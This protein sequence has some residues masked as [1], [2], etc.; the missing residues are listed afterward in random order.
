[1]MGVSILSV[2]LPGAFKGWASFLHFFFIT[3]SVGLWH[4]A[5]LTMTAMGWLIPGHLRDE[6]WGWWGLGKGETSK[7]YNAI[8]SSYFL[9]LNWSLSLRNSNC[10]P[11][12]SPPSRNGPVYCTWLVEFSPWVM[13]VIHQAEIWLVNKSVEFL[14]LCNPC[15]CVCVLW[16]GRRADC[17]RWSSKTLHNK[18]YCGITP[19]IL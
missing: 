7:G 17:W 4:T 9:Q 16:K 10:N 13:F 8:S 11:R 18:L 19:Y 14:C 15:V 3:G 1:M 6:T 2:G 5:T 12:R